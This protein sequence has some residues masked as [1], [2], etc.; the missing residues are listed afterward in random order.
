MKFALRSLLIALLAL[1]SSQISAAQMGMT[2]PPDFAGVFAPVVGSGAAYEMDKKDDHQK[3]KFDIAVV[4]KEGSGYWIEY[5]MQSPEGMAYMKAL[6]ARQ[7][8][9]VVVQ[10][11]IVQAPGHPPMDLS[12]VM[13]MHPM[14]S[15]ESKADMR[16]NAQDLGTETITTP[17]GTFACQHWRS[18]KDGS[19]FWL[20]DKVTPW[21]VVKMSGKDQTMTL[22]RVITD[23]K[24]HITGT[25]L[26]MEEMVRQHARKPE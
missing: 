20:S 23:A 10:H 11:M 1:A 7:G 17:A 3:T 9:D 19:E 15:A 6:T 4:G 14:Q 5:S 16:A 25:P 22:V 18:K 2:R 12:S 21:K 13:K 26:S 24:T 8:D